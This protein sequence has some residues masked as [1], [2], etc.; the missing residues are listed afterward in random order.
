MKK[1]IKIN[2]SG[3]IFH[4]DEDAFVILDAYL[5]KLKKH[6]TNKTEGNEIITDI[7]YRIA[8]LMQLKTNEQKQV[9]TID[10][11]NEIIEIM[12]KPE[13]LFEVDEEINDNSSSH[14]PTGFQSRKFYRDI[15]NNV[16]GGVCSGLS[17]HFNIDPIIL[18]ILFIVL[19]IPLAGF[20]VLLYFILWIVIPAAITTQQKMDMKGGN[21]TVSDIEQ[22]VRNEYEKVKDNFKKIKDSDRYQNTRD[23]LNNAGNGF[24]EILNFFGKLILTIIG[25]A[26]IFAGISL[27]ASMFGAFVFSDS[28][29]FWAHTDQHHFLIPDFL[30]SIVSPQSVVLVAVCI[31]ILVAAPI[32]AIIYWG[33]KLTLRFKSNDKVISI[34]A[35]VAWILS[36]IILLGIGLFEV[37]EYAFSTSVDDT[38]EMELE[39]N[40]T[41]YL[42]SSSEI[43]EFSEIYFF[44]EGMDVYSHEDYPDRIYLEPELRIKYTSEDH[45]SI[46]LEKE[47]RGA[48]NGKARKNASNVEFNW[49]LKDSVLTIDPL[50]FHN[51]KDKW[52]FPELD[53]VLYLPEGQKIC[54]DKDLK[55]TFDYAQRA[56]NIWNSSIPGKCWE[57]T[58]DGLDYPN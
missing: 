27:I 48:T 9:I 22:S 15:D 32:L 44:E 55:R 37:K 8:E 54:I 58:R 50:F 6:F 39:E 45:I 26:M 34:V 43:H 5:N 53:I 23:N 17:Q 3:T 19:A 33:L 10:D 7:E 18:R 12:G 57:M 29:M 40:T 25:I 51:N 2:I 20:P 1:T 35:S 31:V 56:D 46:K 14:E 28:V 38:I 47:A 52:A 24:V 49:H 41:L 4:V 30:F 42:N 11:I 13:D 21:Y 16:A 36:A